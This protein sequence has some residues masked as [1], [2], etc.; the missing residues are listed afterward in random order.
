MH[1]Q[2]WF[3]LDINPDPWAVGPLGVIRKNGAIRPFMGMNKQLDDFKKA[4]AEAVKSQNPTKIKGKVKLTCIFWR[5]QSEYATYQAR[6][7]RK[8]EADATNLLKATE[9]ALQGILFDNDR[10][11]ND[12]RSIVAAQGPDVKPGIVICVEP[13]SEIPDILNELPQHVYAEMDRLNRPDLFVVHAWEGGEGD[14]DPKAV[15]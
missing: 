13:S 15:F 12:V 8:N 1:N 5:Q 4:V 14:S 7:A 3:V 11:N 6:T 2:Q 9:D 10:D